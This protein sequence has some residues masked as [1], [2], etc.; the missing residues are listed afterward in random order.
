MKDKIILIT[1]GVILAAA[2]LGIRYW[3]SRLYLP[4]MGGYN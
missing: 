4:E 2:F 3:F 1:M